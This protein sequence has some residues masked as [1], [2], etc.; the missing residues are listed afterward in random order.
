MPYS[1]V[2]FQMTLSD[3]VKYSMTQL[4]FLFHKPRHQTTGFQRYM[5]K[6]AT[7]YWTDGINFEADHDGSSHLNSPLYPHSFYAQIAHFILSLVVPSLLCNMD[8]IQHTHLYPFSCLIKR[9]LLCWLQEKFL[10]LFFCQSL[11]LSSLLWEY[12][13]TWL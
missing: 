8:N 6:T 9:K 5:L 7:H 3:L 11:N 13:A 1:R 10:W 4:S 12:T 2:S